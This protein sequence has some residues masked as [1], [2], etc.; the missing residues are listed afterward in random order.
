MNN[1]K[2]KNKFIYSRGNVP[3]VLTLSTRTDICTKI[4]ILF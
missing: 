4:I 3:Q 2:N 1:N